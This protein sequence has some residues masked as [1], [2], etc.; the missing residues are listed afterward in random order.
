MYCGDDSLDNQFVSA[1]ELVTGYEM[2][3]RDR[4][5]LYLGNPTERLSFGKVE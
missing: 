3:G 4:L 2:S 5:V 1:L